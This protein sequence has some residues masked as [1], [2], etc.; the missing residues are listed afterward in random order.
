MTPMS[1]HEPTPVVGIVAGDEKHSQTGQVLVLVALSLFVLILFVALA[2]D[3]GHFFA[4]RRKMQNAAD[5]GALAGAGAL[6]FGDP[7][8]AESIAHDYAV[9]KNHA[10]DARID[11]VDALTVTVRA[12]ETVDTFFAGIIGLRTVEVSAGATAV[13]GAA[14]STHRLWPMAYSALHWPADPQCGDFILLQQ[15]DA[16]DCVN[17]NCCVLYAFNQGWKIAMFLPCGENWKPLNLPL[18]RRAW[19]DMEG[20]MLGSDPCNAP[21]PGQG[22]QELVDR[23]VGRTAGGAPC[24][25][26]VEFPTC[27]PGP[28]GAR[29]AN[30]DYTATR[31]GET[32]LVPLYDPARS[33]NATPGT[34]KQN[35]QACLLPDDTGRPGQQNRFYLTGAVCLEILEIEGIPGPYAFWRGGNVRKVLLTRIPCDADGNPSAA[36]ASGLGATDGSIARPGEV[37]AVGLVD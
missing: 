29:E 10:Q 37:R 19:I 5:A 30:W 35:E 9:T 7:A 1:K 12:S 32:V 23:I 16:A 3:T 18:D 13:C 28:P 8:E 22:N 26:Y 15:S 6:C 14:Q 24:E 11:V 25:S 36:C 20:G 2:V 4:E 33:S 21:N 27:L 34:H 31:I 17:W